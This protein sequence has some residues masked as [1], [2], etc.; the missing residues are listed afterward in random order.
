M[1]ARIIILLLTVSILSGCSDE[2]AEKNDQQDIA[3]GELITPSRNLIF[4]YEVTNKSEK[5]LSD[6]SVRM[7]LPVGQSARHTLDN[8]KINQAYSIESDA[9]GNRTL[10]VNFDSFSP[11]STQIITLKVKLSDKDSEQLI[12]VNDTVFT[13]ETSLLPFSNV[14]FKAITQAIKGKSTLNTMTNAYKWVV[15]HMSYSGYLPNDYGALY[16][17]Q[18]ARGD[19]TEYM[20]LLA[21]LLRANEIP[22]RLVAG[23]VYPGNHLVDAADYHNWVEVFYQGRW[24]VLDALKERFLGDNMD[25]IAMRFLDSRDDNIW[26]SQKFFASNRLGMRLF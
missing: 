14:E 17:L 23:Y 10:L 22:T 18:K 9:F 21:A 16:A 5:L 7:A 12:E 19:C 20:Y 15:D 4:R 8:I 6:V 1:I 26:H 11:Y 3:L 2:L 24:Q 13:A 25:Y